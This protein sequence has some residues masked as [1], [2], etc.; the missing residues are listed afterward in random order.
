MQA[1]NQWPNS[2]PGPAACL[3]F[4]PALGA[5]GEYRLNDKTDIY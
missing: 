4:Q 1:W 3:G 5:R 2:N